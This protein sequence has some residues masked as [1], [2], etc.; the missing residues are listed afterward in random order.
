MQRTTPN[1]KSII[2]ETKIMLRLDY[3]IRDR[4]FVKFNKVNVRQIW[5]ET[6]THSRAQNLK[7]KLTCKLEIVKP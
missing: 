4:R 6:L 2:D 5:C 7:K 3:K 1:E